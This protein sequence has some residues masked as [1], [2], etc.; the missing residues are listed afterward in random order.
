MGGKKLKVYGKNGMKLEMKRSDK[1]MV[2]AFIC[3][4][5]SQ[6]GLLVQLFIINLSQS[7]Y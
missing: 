4:I 5:C 6:P 2:H 1:D 7:G 3:I